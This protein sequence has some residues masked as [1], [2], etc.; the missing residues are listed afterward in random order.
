MK[1]QYLLKQVRKEEQLGSVVIRS[2]QDVN[3]EVEE[4]SFHSICGPEGSGKSKIIS[5]LSLIDVPSSGEFYFNGENIAQLSYRDVSWIRSTQIGVIPQVI[6]INFTSSVLDNISMISKIM[7]EDNKLAKEKAMYWLQQV[8]L[9]HIAHLSPLE[10]DFTATKKL[11]IAKAMI[12][13]PKIL[14][15]DNIY[16]QIPTTGAEELLNLLTDLNL[17]HGIT[18]VQT[19]RTDR[20]V[21]SNSFVYDIHNGK[22]S[23]RCIAS[24]AA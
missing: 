24:T 20:F 7:G 1:Y 17:Q 2:L 9:D 19:A 11:G 15:A 10:L 23:K 6:N 12:K 4:G 21:K 14:L 13:N 16:H 22:T 18:V 5:I 8:R 3:L